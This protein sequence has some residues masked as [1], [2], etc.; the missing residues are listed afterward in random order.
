[1]YA[2]QQALAINSLSSTAILPSFLIQVPN[3]QQ[4]LVYSPQKRTQPASARLSIVAAG[5]KGKILR[6]LLPNS[7]IQGYACPAGLQKPTTGKA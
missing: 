2:S 6:L 5:R 1:M 3:G 4:V 7:G